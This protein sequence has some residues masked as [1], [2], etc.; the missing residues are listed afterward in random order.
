M[1]SGGVTGSGKLNSP[2]RRAPVWRSGTVATADPISVAAGLRITFMVAAV[3]VVIALAIDMA[4]GAGL[5][6]R[7]SVRRTTKPDQKCQ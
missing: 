4:G 6:R 2:V 5:G 3:L 7:Q 1:I